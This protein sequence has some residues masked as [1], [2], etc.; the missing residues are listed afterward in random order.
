[1]RICAGENDI[2]DRGVLLYSRN[3]SSS[4]FRQ[5]PRG[6]GQI[7]SHFVHYLNHFWIIINMILNEVTGQKISK[8]H[9]LPREIF[10]FRVV[11]Q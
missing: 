7:G 5:H 3:A 6:Y 8:V 1:M 2:P 10:H 11:H 9:V 4:K